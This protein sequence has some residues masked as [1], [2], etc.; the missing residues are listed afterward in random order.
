MIQEIAAPDEPDWL[1]N[2]TSES[3]FVLEDLL[4]DSLYYPASGLNGTPVK[5]LSG[6]IYSFIYADY[7]I[8]KQ[9]FLTNLN[10]RSS[11]CGFRGYSPVLQREIFTRDIVPAGWRP[12]KVPTDPRE[13]EKLLACER[14][15]RPFGH[16]SVW[17]RD[18]GFG[19]E[20]GAARFSFLFLAGEMSA[21]YQGLYSR[22]SIAPRI[23]AIIQPGAIGGEWEGVAH[24]GSFFKKVVMANSAGLPEYL[25]HGGFGYYNSPCWSEYTGPMITRLRERSAGLWRLNR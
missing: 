4:V 9:Q 19:P 14:R 15:C 21:V 12:D 1:S 3:E 25:L 6:N 7:S 20:H 8:T 16:W 17:Q 23:L 18:P 5:F 2:I 10:G 22:L 13:R 11:D 24:D